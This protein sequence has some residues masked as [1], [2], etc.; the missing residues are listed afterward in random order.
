MTER[1][2]EYGR[3]T[4]DRASLGDPGTPLTFTAST[5]GLNRYGYALRNEGWRLENYNANP[6]VLWMHNPYVPPIGRGLAATKD[7][8]VVTEVTFDQQ[9][10]AARVIE[11]KYRRGFLSAVSVGFDFV[12]EAGEP[13][14][15]W[16]RQ[17][18]EKIHDEL[19]YD[20]VE[21]S[22]VTTPADPGALIQQHHAA[23]SRISRELAGLLDEQENPDSDLQATDLQAAVAAELTRLGIQIPRLNAGT[24]DG[25][26]TGVPTD[27]ARTL[28]AAFDLSK[29]NH[30]E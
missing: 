16:W 22:G 18:A 13:V 14:L 6:V 25:A 19:F 12:S 15:D 1:T 4:L 27:A 7:Q 2:P 24:D 30:G 20:L 28:L 29:E 10:E 17:P 9:D 23:L 5:T 8:T 21:L 26:P 3:A 11:S